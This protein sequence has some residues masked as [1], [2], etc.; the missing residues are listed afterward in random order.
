MEVSADRGVGGP[1]GDRG[2]VPVSEG[3]WGEG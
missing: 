2:V 1:G 3:V